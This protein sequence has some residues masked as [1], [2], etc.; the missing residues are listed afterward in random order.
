MEASGPVSGTTGTFTGAVQ[1]QSLAATAGV[2]G[3]SVSAGTGTF[4]GAVTA[5]SLATTGAVTAGALSSFTGGV[6]IPTGSLIV[7]AGDIS[8]PAGVIAVGTALA[9]GEARFFTPSGGRIGAGSSSR[10][11][12]D[13]VGVGFQAGAPVGVQSIS[14]S[15]TDLP[16]VISLANSMRTALRNYN[17]CS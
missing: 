11:R 7:T 1:A 3:A 12:W 16:T 17:L 6:T 14:S 10:I 9:A 8:A 2:T 15:A 13:S 4:T 5:L